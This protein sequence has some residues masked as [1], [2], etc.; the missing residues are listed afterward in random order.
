MKVG[1]QTW[2]LTE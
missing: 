1:R 2:R